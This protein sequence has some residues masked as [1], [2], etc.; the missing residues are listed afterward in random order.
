[1]IVAVSLSPAA[2]MLLRLK[3]KI[4]DLPELESEETKFDRLVR[5]I[6]PPTRFAVKVEPFKVV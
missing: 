1:M 6:V 2:G 3:L 4:G 5:S